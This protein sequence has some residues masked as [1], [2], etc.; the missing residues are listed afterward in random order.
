METIA[1]AEMDQDP[2]GLRLFQAK[3]VFEALVAR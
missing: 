1:S 2:G 3:S